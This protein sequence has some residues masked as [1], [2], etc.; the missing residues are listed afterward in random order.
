MTTQTTNAQTTDTTNPPAGSD[1]PTDPAT[2]QAG[3]EAPVVPNVLD[4]AERG[5][6]A[7]LQSM[8]TSG[9]DV[10]QTDALGRT[11]LMAAAGA[12]QT[13]A[14][15]TRLNAGADAALRDSTRRSARD[16]ALARYDDAGQT[17]ARVLEDAVG[18]PPVTQ[19]NDK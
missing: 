17:I 11:A 19:P 7:A 18:P 3:A 9:A 8:I 4:A 6:V 10:N 13:D 16:H 2:E 1:K 12:G 5:E 15:F 14:V